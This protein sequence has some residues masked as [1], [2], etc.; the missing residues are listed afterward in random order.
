MLSIVSRVRFVGWK[1]GSA[2]RHAL[3]RGRKRVGG[4]RY[5]RITARQRLKKAPGCDP[6][7]EFLG[8]IMTSRTLRARRRGVKGRDVRCADELEAS[9][10]GGRG[11]VSPHCFM[12]IIMASPPRLNIKPSR[13]PLRCMT[14]PA[15]F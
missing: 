11:S 15:W 3:M 6:R 8:K 9:G 12:V 5:I 1:M 7:G 4:G 10:L 2:I 14:T 13:L